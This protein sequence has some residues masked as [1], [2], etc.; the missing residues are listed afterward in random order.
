MRAK[1]TTILDKI[2]NLQRGLK[3]GPEWAEIWAHVEHAR[4]HLATLV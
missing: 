2:D 4:S 1:V 3:Q